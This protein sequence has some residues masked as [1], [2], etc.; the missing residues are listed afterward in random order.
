VR[1]FLAA[2]LLLTGCAIRPAPYRF[3]NP[4][5]G[6]V[7]LDDAAEHGRLRG[8]GHLGETRSGRAPD[9]AMRVATVAREVPEVPGS[10]GDAGGP[11]MWTEETTL[12]ASRAPEAEL[13]AR[14]GSRDARGDVAF[15][16]EAAAA[17]HASGS[18]GAV[19]DGP[20]LVELARAR[21]GLA[22]SDAAIGAGDLLVF[23]RAAGGAAASLVAVALGVDERGVVEMMYVA[24][25]VVRRGF[26]DPA[27]PSVS[28]DADGRI[29]N[30]FLRHGTD[31]PPT[32][33]RYLSG[34]LLAHVIVASR[35]A[36]E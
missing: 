4:V 9:H 1:R 36:S 3:A 24:R 12:W 18:I 7:S 15:A 28:R 14:V 17:I 25:G 11:G 32:G 13:R 27:R 34:E 20:A 31:Y 29:V 10:L 35:L 33:T 22:G 6:A 21:G 23:D 2:S 8:A 30:T 16:V 19:P 5:V 26:V